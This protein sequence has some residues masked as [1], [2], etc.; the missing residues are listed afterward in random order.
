MGKREWAGVVDKTPSSSRENS[1]G[2]QGRPGRWRQRSLAPTG[3]AAAGN[4]GQTERR[5]RASDSLP[6]LWWRRLRESEIDRQ[7]RLT[8]GGAAGFGREMEVAGELRGAVE[9]DGLA[10]YRTEARGEAVDWWLSGSSQERSNGG[11][12]AAW[13][14]AGCRGL[15]SWEGRRR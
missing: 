5:L 6:H 15:R 7:R 10:F 2:G 1:G 3:T 14:S 4:R 9:S 12:C 11:R 13:H 8:G